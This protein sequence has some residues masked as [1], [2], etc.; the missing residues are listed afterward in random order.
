MSLRLGIAA[1][2]V[3]VLIVSATACAAQPSAA[4]RSTPLAESTSAVAPRPTV[5]PVSSPPVSAAVYARLRLI[6]VQMAK[7]N[8]DLH[9]SRMEAVAIDD[10]DHAD[11]VLS[12]DVING[13]GGAGY[14]IEVQGH[15]VCGACS[16]PFGAHPP[17]GTVAD[18]IVRSGTF[19][20]EGGGLSSRWIDL[21]AL[22]EPFSLAAEATSAPVAV[23]PDTEPP[24]T[25]IPATESAGPAAP[26][27]T[28]LAEARAR[29][30]EATTDPAHARVVASAAT[31]AA[32]LRIAGLTV[33]A[34][35]KAT[36]VMFV[37]VVSGRTILTSGTG[38]QRAAS[39][40]FA[41]VF[42][43]DGS[44]RGDQAVYHGAFGLPN[45]VNAPAPVA[46]VVDASQLSTG[47]NL[48]WTPARAD[49]RHD[50]VPVATAIA[51]VGPLP[52]PSMSKPL[53]ALV[54]VSTVHVTHRL[55]WVIETYGIP[56]G[57]ST[58]AGTNHPVEYLETGQTVIDATTG[59]YLEAATF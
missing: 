21:H 22:G 15:F 3:P 11:T 56:V 28:T 46:T 52:I 9:P 48:S 18:A 39:P 25:G 49:A 33:P 23:A 13:S 31:T 7:G 5:S 12:G 51:A 20:P 29:A 40:Q 42:N 59:R 36:T 38:Q 54:Y 6:A 30:L 2:A 43:T 41:V 45:P 4:A 34:S 1:L 57:S 8:A 47:A 53:A 14:V 27:P 17:K 44:G 10:V 55:A 50:A 26:D 24:A 19:V 58:P 35:V 37:V 16:V 32:R